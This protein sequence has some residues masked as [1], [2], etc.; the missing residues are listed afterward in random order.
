LD[1]LST[2]FPNEINPDELLEK[3]GDWSEGNGHP[4][5][6]NFMKMA[7]IFMENFG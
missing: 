5:E 6:K 4:I 7:E 1:N 2:L 3:L